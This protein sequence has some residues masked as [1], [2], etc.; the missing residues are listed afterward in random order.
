M[1]GKMTNPEELAEQVWLRIAPRIRDEQI[2]V[3]REIVALFE[4]NVERR[5]ELPLHS[6]LLRTAFPNGRGRNVVR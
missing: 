5:L 2:L 3:A 4:A 1:T 6:L